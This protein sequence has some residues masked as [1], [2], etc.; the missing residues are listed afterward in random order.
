M[1]TTRTASLRRELSTLKKQRTGIDARIREVERRICDDA[2][3]VFG[4]PKN[5][6][7]EILSI[8]TDGPV[9]GFYQG[10]EL[11]N[12]EAVPRIVRQRED[13]TPSKHRIYLADS[14]T[15]LQIK[16]NKK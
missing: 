11:I 10:H 9:V 13:G 14:D 5:S 7:V 6:K 12:G 16:R 4:I 8:Y 1:G 15:V 3:A 2:A